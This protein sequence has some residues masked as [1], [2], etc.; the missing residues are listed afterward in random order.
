MENYLENKI[1][2][3]EN[4]LLLVRETYM[5]IQE[6]E[7]DGSVKLSQQEKE[8]IHNMKGDYVSYEIQLEIMIRRCNKQAGRKIKRKRLVEQ[9]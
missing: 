6:I 9:Y 7:K 5:N 3:F 2:E 8:F 4:L 1:D